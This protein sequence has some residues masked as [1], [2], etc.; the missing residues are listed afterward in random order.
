[1][2]QL[3]TPNSSNFP[4]LYSTLHLEYPLVLSRFCCLPLFFF[5]TKFPMLHGLSLTVDSLCIMVPYEI[6]TP[7]TK[8]AMAMNKNARP[9]RQ[10]QGIRVLV[11]F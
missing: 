10:I 11:H 1:M 6:A 4:C 8:T 5:Q 2:L 9:A 7:V 3:L